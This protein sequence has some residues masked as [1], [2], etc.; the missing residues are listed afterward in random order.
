W[1]SNLESRQTLADEISKCIRKDY[2]EFQILDRMMAD[3]TVSGLYEVV[4]E[5]ICCNYSTLCL[6]IYMPALID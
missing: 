6:R 1:K 5:I 4:Y 3:E 2:Q